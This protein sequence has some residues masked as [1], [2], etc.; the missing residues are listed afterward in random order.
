[1]IHRH[2]ITDN[3]YLISWSSSQKKIFIGRW[4]VSTYY[5]LRTRLYSQGI[6]KTEPLHGPFR[7]PH[8]RYG[9]IVYHIFTN[10]DILVVVSTNEHS[11]NRCLQTNSTQR[12]AMRLRCRNFRGICNNVSCIYLNDITFGGGGDS[13]AVN[14]KS[15]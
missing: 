3:N 11:S 13:G 10:I 6:W 4:A 2:F 15:I 14:R 8:F 9:Q 1:M 5:A 12:K 7:T